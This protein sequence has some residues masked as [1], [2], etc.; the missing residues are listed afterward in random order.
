MPWT[1]VQALARD[2]PETAPH[3]TS[4]RRTSRFSTAPFTWAIVWSREVRHG[5]VN[6]RRI[7]GRMGSPVRFRRGA[8]PQNGRSGKVLYPAC[9]IPESCEPPFARELPVR[10]V[11]CASVRAACP[12]HSEAT[13]ASPPHGSRRKLS[14]TQCSCL[15]A[16]PGADGAGQVRTGPL[17]VRSVVITSDSASSPAS[18]RSAA[19]SK[20]AAEVAQAWDSI[21]RRRAE[22]RCGRPGWS[23]RRRSP[24]AA[25]SSRTRPRWPRIRAARGQPARGR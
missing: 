5:G 11:R 16:P 7:D 20:Q 24:A 1:T 10:F 15:G 25:R 4:R 21:A 12:C 13:I 9:R 2:L 8:P 18:T 3:L 23:H 14:S 22:R 17:E 19:A 6:H